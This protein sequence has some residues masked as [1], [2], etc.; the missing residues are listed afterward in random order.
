MNIKGIIMQAGMK[1]KGLQEGFPGQE[2]LIDFNDP[3]T[4][5]TLAMKLSEITFKNVR[6]HVKE[7]RIKWVTEFDDKEKWAERFQLLMKWRE[8]ILRLI[9]ARQA[10]FEDMEEELKEVDRLLEPY[11]K[12]G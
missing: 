8:E 10:S 7:S 1:Y 5:D 11:M 6:T 4:E 12:R 2:P 3:F 9:G